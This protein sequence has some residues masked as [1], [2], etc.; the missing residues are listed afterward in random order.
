MNICSVE[1]CGKR[2]FGHGLCNMHYSRVRK[3]GTLGLSRPDRGQ[4]LS[5]PLYEPWKSMDR[6]GRSRAE[7]WDDFW[8]FVKDV[9]ERPTEN[10]YISRPDETAPFAPSNFFWREKV[11]VKR[12]GE[13]NKEYSARYQKE[14]RRLYPDRMRNWRVS[15]KFGMTIHEYDAMYTAQGGTCAIC[16]E[17][18]TGK[19][20]GSDATRLLAVDHCHASGKIR[21][22]LCAGCNT[23]LGNFR[24]N[25]AYLQAA[26]EYLKE[27]SDGVEEAN[28]D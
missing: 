13:T 11:A 28:D 17:P 5:H 14:V 16:K 8:V 18:E 9:G 3:N 22:L 15:H 24:D 25:P 6:R 7:E 20:R 10:H 4:R 12:E 21:G 27:H 1:G 19:S 23:A 2:V 26:I